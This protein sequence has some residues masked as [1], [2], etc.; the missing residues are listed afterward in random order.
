MAYHFQQAM[1]TLVDVIHD[2]RHVQKAAAT[3]QCSVMAAIQKF[4]KKLIRFDNITAIFLFIQS[5]FL[6]L[7]CHR[8]TPHTQKGRGFYAPAIG[9]LQCLGDKRAFELL[10]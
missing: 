2:E 6:N 5:E 1:L 4:I 8:I 10:V 9:V 7:A 3:A